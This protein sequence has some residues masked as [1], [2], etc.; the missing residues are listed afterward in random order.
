[1]SFLFSLG[2]A[3]LILTFFICFLSHLCKMGKPIY[4]LPKRKDVKATSHAKT[5]FAGSSQKSWNISTSGSATGLCSQHALR[6]QKDAVSSWYPLG[7]GVSFRIS[8]L[9]FILN[10]SSYKRLLYQPSI[11][12]PTIYNKL[13]IY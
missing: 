4:I 7:G 1:M 9:L 12:L 10:K 13:N 2:I 8:L 6:I 5:C 11:I 3:G